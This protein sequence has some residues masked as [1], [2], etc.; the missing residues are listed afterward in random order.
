MRLRNRTDIP[1]D[2]IRRM[3]AFAKP[4]GVAGFDVRVSNYGRDGVRG[5][6]Y[7]EGSACHDRACPFVVVSVQRGPRLAPRQAHDGYLPMPAMT[8]EEAVL[9]VLAHEM[10]HLWQSKVRRGRR[11]WGSRGVF[12]E[13]DADAYALRALR[14]WR[15][16]EAMS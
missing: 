16:G 5:V 15:R 7:Y 2:L 3:V 14:H 6:A 10:R 4:P 13:R 8:R 12:S 1:S 11:V 9:T